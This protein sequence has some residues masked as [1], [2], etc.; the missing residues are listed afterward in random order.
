MHLLERIGFSLKAFSGTTVVIDALPADVKIGREGQ[1]LLDV[2]DYYKE[3]QG[4]EFDPFEKMAAAFSCKNAIKSGEP[5]ELNQMHSL[6]DQLFACEE[7]YFCPH[8]RPV[9]VTIDLDEL[10]RKFKRIK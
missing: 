5:L 4:K 2:I 1:I 10:D 8:G 7:P 6:V 3:N 9:I